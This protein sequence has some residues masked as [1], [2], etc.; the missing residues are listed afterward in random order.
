MA[1]SEP[2]H[3]VP[4]LTTPTSST[5][6]AT[7]ELETRRFW[8]RPGLWLLVL[9]SLLVA[10]LY[11]RL[12]WRLGSRSTP[13]PSS[14]AI[15]LVPVTAFLVALAIG[16]A[17]LGVVR[18]LGAHRRRA[19]VAITALYSIGVI[20][21]FADTWSYGALGVHALS[22]ETLA[23]VFS[24]GGGRELRLPPA[25]PLGALLAF[26]SLWALHHWIWRRLERWPK[27]TWAERAGAGGVALAVLATV[28]LARGVKAGSDEL[29]V[30]AAP[31]APILLSGDAPTLER[32][33]LALPAPDGAVTTKRPIVFV[34]VESLRADMLTSDHMPFTHELASSPGCVASGLHVSGGNTT[35]YGTFALLYGLDT[36]L[37]D[38]IQSRP[39]PP[40]AFEVLR[41]SGYRLTG[42]GASALRT[43]NDSGFLVD[44]F[45]EYAELTTTG[46][47]RDDEAA[48]AKTV[49]AL[50]AT[51]PTFTFVF[52]NATHHNYQYP[53]EF[54]R[55]RPVIDVA[56]D[57]FLDDEVLRRDADR[58][59]NRYWNA[60]GYVDDLVRRTMAAVPKDAIVVI[61]GDHGEEFWEHGLLGHAAPR[62]VAERTDVP[63][64]LCGIPGLTPPRIS[65]HVDVWPS[66]MSALGGPTTLF[67]G[68]P[69]QD[70]SPAAVF[71]AGLDFPWKNRTAAIVTTHAR[72]WVATCRDGRFPCLE[73]VWSTSPDSRSEAEGPAA[74]LLE[75]F[76]ARFGRFLVVPPE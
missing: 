24:S 7:G 42:S 32:A 57:H 36:P 70:G 16:G 3:A 18:L 62:F 48:L 60:A 37:F 61:T 39:T 64:V 10:A 46:D 66:V 30:G 9:D 6:L 40:P 15:W 68:A 71:T 2:G 72:H 23:M 73:P 1:S 17:V 14:A 52:F 28:L 33:R 45:D 76:E 54:E 29:V 65:S 26:G 50:Q 53:P 5:T 47:Y 31:L 55:H 11:A 34:L 27:R 22:A 69:L 67:S 49:L 43:W 19:G 35:E 63:M 75:S 25:L 12:A 20:L 21:A 13:A 56:Y 8:L 58:I 41:R 51:G 74:A 59:R 38:V 44:G 4:R